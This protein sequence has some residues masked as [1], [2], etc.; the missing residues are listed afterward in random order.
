MNEVE[1]TFEQKM[2]RSFAAIQG[3]EIPKMPKDI[4]ELDKEIVT[5]Q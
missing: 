2:R 5:S 4:I 3:V 1:E